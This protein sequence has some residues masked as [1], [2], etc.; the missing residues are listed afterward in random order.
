MELRLSCTN[1]SIY[2]YTLVGIPEKIDD[3][4]QDFIQR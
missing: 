3:V 2:K 1:Q 4:A